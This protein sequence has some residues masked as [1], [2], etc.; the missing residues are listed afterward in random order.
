[1]KKII[2][3]H[4]LNDFSGS[5]RVLS[6]VIDMMRSKGADCELYVGSKG[7]GV[8]D[9]VQVPTRRFA[10]T[11][12]NNRWLTLLSY[13]WSQVNLFFSILYRCDR[14]TTVYVNTML[15]FGAALAGRI[16]GANVIYHVHESFLSPPLLKSFLRLVIRLCAN[17]VIYVSYYLQQHEGVTG[18]PGSMIYNGLSE[19]FQSAATQSKFSPL[20]SGKFNIL[21]LTS[22]KA[23]KG[24]NEF[25]ALAARFVPRTDVTFTLVV[26]ASRGDVEAYFGGQKLPEN[27]ALNYECSDVGAFYAQADLVMNLSHVD[28]CVETFGLTV[29]EAMSYGIPV[30]APP[31]GGPVELVSEGVEGYQVDS[32]DQQRLVAVV[33]KLIA[34]SQLCLAHSAR[35]RE[36]AN[37]FSAANFRIN[38]SKVF[39]EL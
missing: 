8:L 22:L 11:R 26:S 19:S 9:E 24:V 1:M 21:M 13:L 23:Y 16:R 10:Y 5:P 3:V 4:L 28:D 14:S 15:P 35:A 39:D 33:E 2:F 30:I 6:Q 20:R 17:H 29:L 38:I 25:V 31:V 27:M 36:K 37:E 12:F 18:V 32:R 34:D 7:N